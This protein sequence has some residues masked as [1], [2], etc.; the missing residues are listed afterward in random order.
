MHDGPGDAPVESI[1]SAAAS[2][3]ISHAVIATYAAAAAIEVAGVHAIAGGQPGGVDPDRVPKGVRIS[4]DG[5]AVG[6]ELHLVTEWG[7]SIPAV[8]E[9]GQQPRARLPGV[10]DRARALLGG[11]RDRRRRAARI[12][13][14]VEHL[15]GATVG[16]AP[17]PCRDCMW[18]QTRPG[19]QARRPAAMEAGAGGRVRAVGQAVRRGRSRDR[20]DPVRPQRPV[21][22]RPPS[23]GRATRPR[24][25]A[26]HVRLPDRRPQ[27]VGAAEPVPGRDRRVP[28]P[29]AAG[30]GGVRLPVPAGRGV[31]RP[32][33]RP[34]HDLPGRLPARPRL[35]SRSAA[36][37]ASSLERL[38]LRAIERAPDESRLARL[39]SRLAVVPATPA[40]VR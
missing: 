12:V 23:A 22:P 18:W 28:R 38:D 27:P 1:H 4:A 31:R 33:P 13:T 20:A 15:T 16:V 9:R 8:A 14:G 36:P 6:L 26:G 7:A 37:G 3:H 40:G 21:R 30:A 2:A 17:V 29:R 11:G 32:V 24:R 25:G 34:P 35:P 19:R 10:D 39:R 5:D